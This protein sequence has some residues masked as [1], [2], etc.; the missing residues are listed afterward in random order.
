MYT[1]SDG[2]STWRPLSLPSTALS[3]AVDFAD[4]NN[5]WDL[6]LQPGWVRGDP[7]PPRD[8]LYHSAD[9]G[10]TWSVVARST[11]INYPVLSPLNIWPSL[12]FVDANQ[13]FIVQPNYSPELL[14][15]SDGGRTWTG[16]NPQVS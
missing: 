6:I 4:P 13:G 10:A 16:I 5:F 1:T 2:G 3:L 8:W 7:T 11:P 14:T 9:G 12:W 15:T